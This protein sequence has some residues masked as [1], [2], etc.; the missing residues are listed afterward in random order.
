MA[1][2]KT[3]KAQSKSKQ[4][5]VSEHTLAAVAS[6]GELTASVGESNH[7]PPSAPS[8]EHTA[9]NGSGPKL[10]QIQTRAYEI[11]M[12]RGASHGQDWADWFRAE[13]EL[14][15]IPAGVH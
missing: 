2:R 7:T 10:E 11:F 15:G 3:S 6:N 14:K 5:Q 8:F 1:P 12:A 4:A 13:Q 9:T